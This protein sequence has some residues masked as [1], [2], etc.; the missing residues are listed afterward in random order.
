MTAIH[1]RGL[2]RREAAEHLTQ[3]GF[4][5]SPGT[6]AK[7]AV[8]G[9]GPPYR[10]FGCRPLYF[11]SDLLNWAQSRT[12]LPRRSTSE[13]RIFSTASGSA[14][15]SVEACLPAIQTSDAEKKNVR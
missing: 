5:V 3:A 8:T 6:L 2:T 15:Q 7:Y 13:P 12:T 11:P 9:S 10:K 14:D 1:E 4:R